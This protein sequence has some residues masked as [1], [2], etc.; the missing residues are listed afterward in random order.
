[1][2]GLL[3]MLVNISGFADGVS[4]ELIGSNKAQGPD[5]SML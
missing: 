4:V 2:F 5:H 3:E 1:M